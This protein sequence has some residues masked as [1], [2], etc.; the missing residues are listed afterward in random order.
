M[1]FLW[2]IMETEWNIVFNYSKNIHLKAK[3]RK[4]RAIS[5]D[6][7]TIKLEIRND[8]K[9][10][11]DAYIGNL[12]QCTMGEWLRNESLKTNC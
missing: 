5:M 1:S 2:S 6:I 11:I 8:F 7:I 9:K 3:M 10:I 4:K 12:A